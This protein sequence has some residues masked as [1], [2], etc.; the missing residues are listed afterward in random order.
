MA[1]KLDLPLSQNWEAATTLQRHMMVGI[2][3][4][5]TDMLGQA[6]REGERESKRG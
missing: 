3:L 6:V 5:E 2:C 4:L 1:R